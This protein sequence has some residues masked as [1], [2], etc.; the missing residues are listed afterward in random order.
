MKQFLCGLVLSLTIGFLPAA[1]QPYTEPGVV[2]FDVFLQVLESHGNWKKEKEGWL[3]FPN[4]AEEPSW[5]PYQKGK[6]LYTDWGWLWQGE[7]SFANVCYYYGNW[8]RTEGKWSWK[9][10]VKWDP[11]HVAWRA[12]GRFCGWRPKQPLS[13]TEAKPED[14]FFVPKTKLMDSIEIKDFLSQEESA[15]ALLDSE[16]SEHI[17]TIPHYRD[18]VRPG[19]PPKEITALTGK[20]IIR[21]SVMCLSKWD[22]KRPEKYDEHY[23]FIYRPKIIQD[24]GGIQ[25]R[26]EFWVKKTGEKRDLNKISSTIMEE[27]V[28]KTVE[29]VKKQRR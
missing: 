14:W 22:E 29:E 27:S 2:D 12:A 1:I 10:G 18:F 9:P 25:R 5:H 20:T 24:E 23:L 6:W 17:L 3:Y 15:K 21:H 26:I 16:V 19:P 28:K 13:E 11:D 4:L 8:M 7:E